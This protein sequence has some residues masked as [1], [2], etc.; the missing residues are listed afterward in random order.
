MCSRSCVPQILLASVALLFGVGCSRPN[1]DLATSNLWG[2]Y[3]MRISGRLDVIEIRRDG[4]YEHTISAGGK[5]SR[6]AGEWTA[7]RGRDGLFV[8]LNHFDTSAWPDELPGAGQVLNYGAPVEV[9]G[10]QLALPVSSDL[11]LRYLKRPG[12]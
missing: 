12:R 1:R 4:T 8:S 10:T 5:T 3:E 6:E 9:E 11:G 7:Y 2:T